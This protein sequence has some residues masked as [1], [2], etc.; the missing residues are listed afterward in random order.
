MGQHLSFCN[1]YKEQFFGVVVKSQ[2]SVLF[3][4]WK[5]NPGVV[6][7]FQKFV[8]LRTSIPLIFGSRVCRFKKDLFIFGWPVWYKIINIFG[9]KRDVGILVIVFYNFTYFFRSNTDT[10]NR[11]GKLGG[12]NVFSITWPPRSI[13]FQVFVIIWLLPIS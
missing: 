6:R 12:F 1:L 8:L 2:H 4:L 10:V 11:S 7:V 9:S 3:F 5:L 13:S